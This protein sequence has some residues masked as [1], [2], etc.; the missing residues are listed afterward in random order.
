MLDNFG[1]GEFF[2]LALL[3]LLFFGPERLPQMGAKLGQWIAKLTSYSRTFMTEWREEALA[4][5]EAVAEVRGIRDEI[6]AAQQEISGSL[7][8]A[9]DDVTE[10]IE[11]AKEA[12]TDARLEVEHNLQNQRRMATRDLNAMA[13]QEAARQKAEASEPEAIDK[14]R[15]ILANLRQKQETPS[16]GTVSE[17]DTTEEL[18]GADGATEAA[19]STSVALSPEEEWERNQRAIQELMSRSKSLPPS[20]YH[21]PAAT[22]RLKSQAAAEP[23]AGEVKDT[24]PAP[25]AEVAAPLAQAIE[26]KEPRESAYDRTQKILGNLS[27]RRSG[28]MPTQEEQ[29][30]EIQAAA[31]A[32]E[33]VPAKEARETAFDR[34]QQI[35]DNLK[36]RKSAAV[37]STE[38]VVERASI[39]AVD[40]EMLEQ[41]QAQVASLSDQ[42]AALRREMETIRSASHTAAD[43]LA[44]EEA[45]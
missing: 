14:T 13:R 8:T 24:T 44:V 6:L 10:G 12:V 39:P 23:A 5:Q 31:P 45:L 25:P 3:A 37:P 26:R 9:R 15:Q 20:L 38:P 43:K 2:F 32:A 21:G 40:R 16:P 28:E 17:P 22:G 29:P 42:I 33:V 18:P 27:R 35:L 30:A 41:L 11:L 1:L 34:T 4:I 7:Q 36:K 19:P